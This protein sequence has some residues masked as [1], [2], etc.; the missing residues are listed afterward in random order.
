MAVVNLLPQLPSLEMLS[1]KVPFSM[2]PIPESASAR[3]AQSLEAI[4]EEDEGLEGDEQAQGDLESLDRI[5][6]ESDADGEDA[7]PFEYKPLE[8]DPDESAKTKPTL[9]CPVPPKEL[10]QLHSLIL[11]SPTPEV[12]VPLPDVLRALE[13]PLH[14]L[15]LEDDCGS[16]TPGILTSLLP[17]SQE[18]E[19][20]GLGV[21]YS[22]KYDDLSPFLNELSKLRRLDLYHYT[23]NFIPGTT[24]PRL[25]VLESFKVRHAHTASR[26]EVLNM[27]VW[28]RRITSSSPLAVLDVAC[29]NPRN[30]QKGYRKGLLGHA[31]SHD[32]LIDHLISRHRETLRIL[33]LSSA[34]IGKR[35]F[36]KMF[37]KEGEGFEILEEVD[38]CVRKQTFEM[39]TNPMNSTSR[40]REIRFTIVNLKESSMPKVDKDLL[41]RAQGKTSLRTV[42]I[43]GHGYKGKWIAQCEDDGS[44]RTPP[45]LNAIFHISEFSVT[46]TSHTR[47][48]PYALVSP[49]EVNFKM[50]PVRAI[51]S[52]R[53]PSLARLTL[54]RTIYQEGATAKSKEFSKKEKAHEGMSYSLLPTSTKIYQYVKQHEALQLKRI[55]AEIELK[56]AELAKLEKEHAEL[57]NSKPT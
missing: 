13:H 12:L 53:I 3:P 11:A 2:P 27:C 4:T 15:C 28:I 16:V 30:C 48:A 33:R 38:I 50:L 46:R 18:L 20:F 36:R 8:D 25:R 29:E 31:I 5:E 21:A 7:E 47:H 32:G 43:N 6:D 45:K 56:K 35:A 39:F 24:L 23:Q 49:T 14:T 51:T 10:T 41:E 1:I 40:L 17:V 55:R 22:L 44:Q 37:G 19:H 52:R 57:E 42:L 9:L 34:Y 26:K 54:A